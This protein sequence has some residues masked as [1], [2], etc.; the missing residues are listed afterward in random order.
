MRNIK[1]RMV[2]GIGDQA[3]LSIYDEQS[4]VMI[5][6]MRLTHEQLGLFV[7]GQLQTGL[8]ARVGRLSRVGWK[9]HTRDEIVKIPTAQSGEDQQEIATACA[10]AKAMELE[11]QHPGWEWKPRTRDCM[12]HHNIK[13]RHDEYTLYECVFY[14]LE[15]PGE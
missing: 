9:S 4:D 11:A 1:A 8:D 10:E 5:V 2:M 12:N 7:S 15:P 13:E 14:G 3:H 6:E